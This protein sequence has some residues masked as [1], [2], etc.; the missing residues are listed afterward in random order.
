VISIGLGARMLVCGALAVVVALAGQPASGAIRGVGASPTATRPESAN[1]RELDCVRLSCWRGSKPQKATIRSAKRRTR[2]LAAG[3]TMKVI[4][5]RGIR[6]RLAAPKR[7]DQQSVILRRVTGLRGVRGLLS[8]GASGLSI[9]PSEIQGDPLVLTFRL[10]KRLA[11]RAVVVAASPDGGDLHRVPVLGRRV[12]LPV[13][14]PMSVMVVPGAGRSSWVRAR[15]SAHMPAEPSF[16]IEHVLAGV[17]RSTASGPTATRTSSLSIIATQS[18]Q[19][20]ASAV[21]QTF[22]RYREYIQWLQAKYAKNPEQSVDTVAR[23]WL[24]LLHHAQVASDMGLLDQE[25]VTQEATA[26]TTYL[27]QSIDQWLDVLTEPCVRQSDVRTVLR[28]FRRAAIDG[29]ELKHDPSNFDACPYLLTGTITATRDQELRDDDY[30]GPGSR[31]EEHS[32][33]GLNVRAKVFGPLAAPLPGA[34]GTTIDQGTTVDFAGSYVYQNSADVGACAD[35]WD[36]RYAYGVLGPYLGPV[37]SIVAQTGET[38]RI[39]ITVSWPYVS[40][41]HQARLVPTTSGCDWANTDTDT[42]ETESQ[43]LIGLADRNGTTFQFTGRPPWDSFT[44]VSGTL[45]ATEIVE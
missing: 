40:H 36:Y 21:L 32:T 16:K 30:V 44:Q 31:S 6:A 15:S 20:G 22:N 4:L 19:D 29:L 27:G 2:E 8:K 37:Q 11:S 3:Q 23:V 10:S 9:I 13:L 12:N 24:A 17:L 7:A 26:F 14:Q 35:M 39:A 42:A 45:T 18:H 38:G 43:V 1:L 28:L 41:D 5:G 25:E 33:A 34:S